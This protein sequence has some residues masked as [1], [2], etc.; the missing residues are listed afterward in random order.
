MFVCF[1][2]FWKFL[3]YSIIFLFRCIKQASVFLFIC[4]SLGLST[5]LDMLSVYLSVCRFVYTRCICSLFI[6]LSLGLST[7]LHMLS[8]YLSV[9]RFVN[10]RCICCL[11]ICL[12]LRLSILNTRCICS[13]FICLSLGLSILAAY[14]LCLSVCLC[15]CASESTSLRRYS[16][17]REWRRKYSSFPLGHSGNIL[18]TLRASYF[19][20]SLQTGGLFYFNTYETRHSFSQARSSSPYNPSFRYSL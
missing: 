3:L 17:W 7:S 14:A 16:V 15:L 8:V 19:S 20:I 9:S 2:T 13:L 6:C 12:S 10:T 5:S 11:F 1:F 4:L 18:E